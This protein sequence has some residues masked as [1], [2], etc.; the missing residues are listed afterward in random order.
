MSNASKLN[1][2]IKRRA[3]IETGGGDWAKSKVHSLGQLTARERIEQLLD[4]NS[5]VEIGVFVTHRATDFNMN[6]QKTPTDGVVTGYGTLGGNLVYIYSQDVNILKGALGEMHAKK[7][8]NL[9]NLALKIGAPIIGLVDSAGLRLQEST[10]ALQ[11]FGELFVKQS[12]ASGIIPQ[13]IAILG[14]CGGGASMIPSLA[15]FT[16]MTSKNAR[17]YVNSPNALDSKAASF[18]T[19][20]S[21]KFHSEESGMVD[22]VFDNEE[23]LLNGIRKIIELL[24]ENNVDDTPSVD[25]TDDLNRIDTE[26]NDMDISN[27]I[28]SREIINKIADNN[29]FFEVKKNYAETMVTGLLRLNGNTVGVVANYTLDN[30]G[31]LTSEACIKAVRFIRICDAFNIPIL[32][33]TDVTGF[34]ASIKEE[35]KSLGKMVSK[36]LFAFTNATVPKVNVIVGRGYGSAYIAMNSKHIGAD[37]VYAWPNARIGM[38]EASSAVKIMYADDIKESDNSE[39]LISERSA[40]FEDLQSS[41]YAAASHGYIDDIIEPAATRKR[42]I[43]AF[44]MLFSKTEE[45]PDKKHDTIL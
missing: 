11:G 40:E 43:A 33:L 26:L 8:C 19:V 17:L 2:L 10:D 23:D 24:P 13:I 16:F 41:P 39:A 34:Y 42:V 7:I 35:Q 32:T 28:N 44:E 9:Y 25:T 20:A 21:A 31:T 5:F 6:Q 14:N 36:M 18:D 12:L 1:E 22:F 15:D 37:S 3:D 38:M 45:R 30:D 4:E 29:D 27:G